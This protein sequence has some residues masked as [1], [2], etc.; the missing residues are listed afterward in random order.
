MHNWPPV[1]ALE[2]D[3]SKARQNL[4]KHGV[5]FELA[6]TIFRDTQAISIYDEEHRLG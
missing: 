1:Y 6:A 2:W 3:P 5:T 4:I